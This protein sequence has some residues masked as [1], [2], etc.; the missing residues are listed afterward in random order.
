V[1]WINSNAV[2][3][4][5]L[6]GY[7]ADSLAAAVVT[8]INAASITDVSARTINGSAWVLTATG[9]TN[10]TLAVSGAGAVSDASN[11][12]GSLGMGNL[13]TMFGSG[14]TATAVTNYNGESSAIAKAVAINGIKG[15]SGV[16]GTAQENEVTATSAVGAVTLTSGDVYI[17]GYDIGAATVT[18][19]DSTGTL[20]TAINNQTTST[21]V[22]GSIDANGKLVLTA[23]D[24]RN[25]TITTKTSAIGTSLG[26]SGTATNSTYVY[27]SSVKLNDDSSFTI[28]SAN[29]IA[30][31]TGSAGTSLSVASDVATYNVAGITIDTSDHAQAAILTIDAA[32]DDVNAIRAQ[33]GAVQ[34]RLEFTVNNLNIASENMSASESRIRDA[35]FAAE[36]ATFTRNQIMVQAGVAMVAQAN[37]TTQIALQLLR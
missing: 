14:G 2:S 8:A 16:T 23:T 34:N 11:I 37:T 15:S 13:S 4:T 24:G 33:I 3:L 27:R 1:L 6:S 9:G 32:L 20:V 29:S 31:L 19:N 36:V 22:S 10:L 7:G 12:L 25:I 18:A 30:D 35:D 28:T 17:N 21:G 26:L 5:T